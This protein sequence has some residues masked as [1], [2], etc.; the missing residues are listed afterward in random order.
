MPLTELLPPLWSVVPLV[1]F[2]VALFAV[3]RTFWRPGV[4]WLMYGLA[5]AIM[6]VIG[7]VF[8][9]AGERSEWAKEYVE[10]YAILFGM[11]WTGVQLWRS[12][13][14]LATP[15]RVASVLIWILAYPAVTFVGLAV[16]AA[17]GRYL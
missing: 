3:P 9:D 8:G 7:Y 12:A 15:R 4:L 2:T 17:N 10:A 1:V 5:A 6:G 16:A 11:V 14:K 13:G